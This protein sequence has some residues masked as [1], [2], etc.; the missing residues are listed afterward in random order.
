MRRT[1]LAVLL[2]LAVAPLTG[3]STP[4][5]WTMEQFGVHKRDILV[6]RVEE[7]RDAQDAAKEQFVSALDAFK[8]VHAFDGGD[9]EKL[10]TKLQKEYDRSEDRAAAV[11]DR[12]DSVETVSGDL[13]AEWRG[14][15]G[16]MHDAKLRA[17]SED[18]LHRTEER[19]AVL[20][21]AMHKAEA[22]MQ[23]VLTSFKD[24]VLALKHNLNAQAVASL[25][26]ELASIESE[27]GAL[28][29]DMEASIAEADAFLETLSN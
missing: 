1:T 29:A 12:I 23:P 13:F 22:S 27:I 26:G 24:H 2:A 20:V 19:Y 5:Y 21:G 3:C 6:D 10:Y 17:Q 18:L 28:V 16:E 8:A 7:A 4:Y 15:I 11:T 14:E 25:S 9:L